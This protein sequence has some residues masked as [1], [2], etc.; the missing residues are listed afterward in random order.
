MNAQKCMDSGSQVMISA[1]PGNR[2]ACGNCG[3][4]VV[5]CRVPLNSDPQDANTIM[6]IA[7]H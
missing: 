4:L 3:A 6:V 2:I 5:V 1:Q 7:D